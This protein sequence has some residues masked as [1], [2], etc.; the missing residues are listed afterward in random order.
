MEKLSWERQ[1]KHIVI[2]GGNRDIHTKY[3]KKIKA[4]W[5]AIYSGWSTSHTMTDD[6]ISKFIKGINDIIEADQKTKNLQEFL[7][8]ISPVLNKR[9]SPPVSPQKPPV[10]VESIKSTV[11]SRKEQH[12]FHRETS[13]S[14]DSSSDDGPKQKPEPVSNARL[15]EPEVTI[16]T[17]RVMST[18]A[19]V[20]NTPVV[21]RAEQN[22]PVEK[23][24]NNK[25]N[26][27]V[28]SVPVVEKNKTSTLSDYGAKQSTPLVVQTEQR[29]VPPVVR[30]QKRIVSPP[31]SS[32]ESSETSSF[33]SSEEESPSPKKRRHKKKSIKRSARKETKHKSENT[34]YGAK[35][36]N[37]KE[38]PN[39]K[40]RD[41]AKN[42]GNRKR[43]SDESSDSDSS[44]EY[45]TSSSDDFPSPHTP[46]KKRVKDDIIEKAKRL[47]RKMKR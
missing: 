19:S 29:S 22:T 42:K 46:K 25:K 32:S 23:N 27:V 44:S 2:T 36:S 40:Y 16:Q 11:R 18:L 39:K 41:M 7:Q 14:E 38:T 30:E 43:S 13:R 5:T 15:T 35:Q 26:K 33:T 8:K 24:T 1:G 17:K 9:G 21:V 4:R 31:A 45:D 6:E 20:A 34:D 3:L 47:Q 10:N 28:P 12:K 37:R